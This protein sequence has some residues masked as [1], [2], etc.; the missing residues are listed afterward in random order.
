VG[1][2]LRLRTSEAIIKLSQL[3]I[4]IALIGAASIAS[5]K[6]ADPAGLNKPYVEPQKRERR[7]A[8]P[9]LAERGL[10]W[11]PYLRWHRDATAFSGAGDGA[12][13]GSRPP[14]LQL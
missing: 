5:A 3:I 13:L 2:T 4:A 12:N 7:H 9:D 11:Q 14:S 10:D 1:L 8:L 6:D